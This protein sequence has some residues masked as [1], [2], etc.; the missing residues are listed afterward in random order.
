MINRLDLK[1]GN[2]ARPYQYKVSITLPSIVSETLKLDNRTV[3][4][5]CRRANVPDMMME[6]FSLFVQGREVKMPFGTDSTHEISLSFYNDEDYYMRHVLEYWMLTIDA[7]RLYNKDLAFY[8]KLP[9]SEGLLDTIIDKAT[10][11]AKSVATDLA[12]DI[13]GEIGKLGGDKLSTFINS[14]INELNKTNEPQFGTVA[15][16]PLT[17]NGMEICTYTLLNAYPI[18]LSQIQFANDSVGSISEFD[19]M[20]YFTHYTIDK[21]TMLDDILGFAK[22]LF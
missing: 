1:L 17:Y 7:Y 8:S 6:Q 4:T 5:L 16:T 15:I 22:K 2:G 12:R 3:D 18:N 9:P 14:V 20:F 13:S 11:L 21:P 10:N 19:S